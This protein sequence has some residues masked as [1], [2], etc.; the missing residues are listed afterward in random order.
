[1]PWKPRME[2]STENARDSYTVETTKETFHGIRKKSHTMELAGIFCSSCAC[3]ASQ[4]PSVPVPRPKLHLFFD[5]EYSTAVPLLHLSAYRIQYV[6]GY[7]R[8]LLVQIIR[9]MVLQFFKG[10]ACVVA[11]GQE[12][13]QLRKNSCV[14]G[15]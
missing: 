8:L 2:A 1:M 15:V 6:C 5:R 11:P 12:F 4:T 14:Q 7:L 3:S 10:A 13:F 9:Q